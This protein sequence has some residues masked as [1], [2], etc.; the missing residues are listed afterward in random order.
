MDGSTAAVADQTRALLGNEHDEDVL[1]AAAFH[2][3][4]LILAF[5]VETNDWSLECSAAP[6][7]PGGKL[8]GST[9]TQ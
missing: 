4:L 9:I 2:S 1:A 7:W 3:E 8:I 5:T 6:A